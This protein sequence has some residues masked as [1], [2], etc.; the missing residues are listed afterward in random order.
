MR[1]YE[2]I[3]GLFA[4]WDE[5]D[6]A[7]PFGELVASLNNLELE[8]A[9]LAGALLFA[10]RN[11]RRVAIRR[12]PHYEAL[13]L[14]W[15]SGQRS[16]IHNHLGSSCVVRVVEG[17]A[18]ETSYV[19]SP[20]GKLVPQRSRTFASGT[21]AACRD[22]A[23]HQMA[24][25]EPPGQD[26]ITLHVYSPPPSA[27]NYFTLDRTTLADHDAL[28]HEGAQ[29]VVVD[30]GKLASNCDESSMIDA[31]PND[32]G[33]AIAV[34]GGGFSGTMVAVHLGQLTA[35]TRTRVILLERSKGPGRGVAYG[36][37][38]DRHLLNVPAGLMSALPDAPAHFLDWLRARDATAHHGTF[39]PRRVYGDYLE[40]V[41]ADSTRK[42]MGRIEIVQDEV[43]DVEVGDRSGPVR[44]T[45]CG[46]ERIVAE[47]V[48][49]ALGHSPPADPECLERDGLS[50]NYFADPWSPEALAELGADEAIA[51]IGTG[52]TAV[53]LIVEA[54][55]RGHR[56]T[57]LA[58]SRHGLLP[59][60]HQ[61]S[62]A[63]P[64]PHISIG[65]GTGETARS[66]LKR[67][68]SLVTVCN[69]QGSDWRSAVDS[70]RP[71]TQ[72]LWRSLGD[73]ERARFI[74]HLAPRW[75]VHRHR[76]APQIDELL[77]DR[78][79][80]GRLSVVAGRVL[81][82]ASESGEV[83]VTF[84]RRGADNAER[85]KVRR[86]INCTGPA[87]NVEAGSSRLLR[88]LISRGVGRPGPLAL[89]LDVADSGSLI[90]RDGREN[91]R[92][93]A[94]GPL[95]KERLWETTAVRELRVQAL[96]LAQRLRQIAESTVP[97]ELS[98]G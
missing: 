83:V 43:V 12:R 95:L 7:I 53:D 50:S 71:V 66:L 30:F 85:T 14:C 56:G 89:G 78:R 42:S 96:E 82:L 36:T 86:V 69:E 3:L 32:A 41:L 11:Y 92:I 23:I 19:F 37:R 68:R 80:A 46:G 93:Y 59:C 47:R 88:S 24:N 91:D 65:A 98:G 10:D 73:L 94:I 33:R 70:L 58:I 40:E 90:G 74:R 4:A 81:S 63:I 35:A 28:L 20:C 51:L 22:E 87:R 75:D 17:R 38:C 6:D 8:R 76:V 5:R 44:L 16:P 97:D 13:V 64:R 29:T 18:T 15:K 84:R 31:V 52:L 25:L 62:P 79:R 34:V 39:A 27:W 45:T 49:L 54:D 21:V 48:V 55:A 57:I 72:T 1:G 67:V 9:D 26:L 77:Q 60:R 61:S 2:Q